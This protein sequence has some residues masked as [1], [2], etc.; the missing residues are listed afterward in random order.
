[1]TQELVQ[2]A[3]ALAEA[4]AEENRALESLTFAQAA[5]LLEAKTRATSAFITAQ[6]REAS[7]PPGART[8]RQQLEPTVV[9]LRDLAA[10]NKRLLE[11]AIIVQ[12][13]V[14]GSIVDAIPKAGSAPRYG[15]SGAFAGGHVRPMA[16]SARA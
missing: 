8:R 4:L 3:I 13:R 14:I 16:L 5:T 10:E 9:R 15:A 2:S 6:A 12:R 11:R 1:M 7:A